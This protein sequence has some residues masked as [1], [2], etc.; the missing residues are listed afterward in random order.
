MLQIFAHFPITKSCDTW[1]NEQHNCYSSSTI[2]KFPFLTFDCECARSLV[3]VDA[4]TMLN[5]AILLAVTLGMCFSMM[6]QSISNVEMGEKI[7]GRATM[8]FSLYEQQ[9]G[10]ILAVF[11]MLSYFF[12]IAR[13]I[14]VPMWRCS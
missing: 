8:V 10:A 4:S 1:N 12:A 9:W 7:F 5:A 13:I 6:P 2:K 11:F 3:V 14:N